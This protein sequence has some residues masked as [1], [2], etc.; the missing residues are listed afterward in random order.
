M[1]KQF[2]RL[3]TIRDQLRRWVV[4]FTIIISLFILLPTF[5]IEYRQTLKD[6]SE[7]MDF[8]LDS[9][10]YFF[11][12][13]LTERSRDIHTLANLEMVKN[14]E[15]EKSREVFIEHRDQSDF[16]DIIFVSKEG[17]VQF[18]T[19]ERESMDGVVID[20]NDREYFQVA[21]AGQQQFIT[22]ILISKVTGKPILAFAS[23]IFDKNNNFNGV[24]FGTVNLSTI[25]ELLFESRVGFFGHAYIVNKDG[26]L[27]TEHIAPKKGEAS[28]ASEKNFTENYNIAPHILEIAKDNNGKINYYKNYNGE[29]VLGASN[30]IN[31]ENWYLISEVP[32]LEAHT[33]VFQKMFLLIISI[34]VGAFA[35]IKIM[36]YF[37]RKFEEPVH[38]LIQGLH[39]IQQG[40]YDYKIDESS[41]NR[42]A[43]EFQELGNALNHMGSKVKENVNLLE[44]LSLS[45]PLTKLYNRRYLMEQGEVLLHQ[46]ILDN[47]SCACIAVDIDFFKNVNDTYGHLVGDDVLKFIAKLMQKTVRKTDI[48]T[49]YGGEEFIILLP[50]TTLKEASIVAEKVLRSIEENPFAKNELYIPIT[51]SIGV[52]ERLEVG[53]VT[54]SQLIHYADQAL[55]TSKNNGRN[56]VTLYESTVINNQ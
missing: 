4:L 30:P 45:C 13:W 56:K 14:Y 8:F 7:K 35:T 49:R 42:Y 27:L 36:L 15:F 33:A 40:D 38:K 28:A 31:R 1:S 55:Y 51:V 52:A 32:V 47:Q 34:L 16:T 53:A 3:D 26:M 12:S 39:N 2:F 48:V 46:A 5:I 19:V 21:K 17:F 37:A 18:D 24:V 54:I 23:P 22:D 6:Q 44:A 43:V 41:I 25:D 11:E 10:H 9:Q 20:V 50:N 29:W